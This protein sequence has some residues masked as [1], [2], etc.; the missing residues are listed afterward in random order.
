[1]NIYIPMNFNLSYMFIQLNA[2]F[3]DELETI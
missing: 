1:M 3:Y 2:V